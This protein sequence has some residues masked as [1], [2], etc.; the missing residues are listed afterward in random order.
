MF[1]EDD[2]V[3]SVALAEAGIRVLLFDHSWNRDVEHACIERV[4]GWGDVAERLG[5]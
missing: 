5:V 2:R 1:C 3:I 4:N